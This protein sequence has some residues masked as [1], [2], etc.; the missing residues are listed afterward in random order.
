[1]CISRGMANAKTDDNKSTQDK[2]DHRGPDT[3]DIKAD[4]KVL[5]LYIK[6]IEGEETRAKY[7]PDTLVGTVKSNAL[8]HF[9]IKPG[10]NDK[11]RLA[12]R[13]DH[14]YRVLDDGKTLADEGVID[15]MTLWLG[16]EQVVGNNKVNF[17]LRPN[18]H[19]APQAPFFL[20]FSNH[21]YTSCVRHCIAGDRS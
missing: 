16:V 7:A 13:K 20:L 19:V 1:M 4:D 6:T 17:C 12:E 18:R 21:A 8:E 3:E 15:E 10:P 14:T 5:H 9:K 2:P 11:Y